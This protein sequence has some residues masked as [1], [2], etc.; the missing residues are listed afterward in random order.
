MGITGDLSRRPTTAAQSGS[1]V[2]V[3]DEDLNIGIHPPPT[4]GLIIQTVGNQRASPPRSGRQT[5]ATARPTWLIPPV[6]QP[7]TTAR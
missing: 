3:I 6:H 1:R 7:S 2:A 5:T 4:V